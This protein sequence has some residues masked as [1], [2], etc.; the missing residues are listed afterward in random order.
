V[1][2]SLILKNRNQTNKMLQAPKNSSI[3][4]KKRNPFGNK[5]FS[6]KNYFLI[7]SKKPAESFI[8]EAFP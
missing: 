6:K 1:G 5:K 3:E 4:I 8:L 7:R 2:G